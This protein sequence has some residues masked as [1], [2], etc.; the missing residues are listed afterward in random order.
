MLQ[1]RDRIV[2]EATRSVRRAISSLS[3]FCLTSAEFCRVFVMAETVGVG[4][5]IT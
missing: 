3:C 2:N 4:T 5:F 1:R